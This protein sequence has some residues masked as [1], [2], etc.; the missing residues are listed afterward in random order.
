M[1]RGFDT[2]ECGIRSYEEWL[3][4]R[5]NSAHWIW[6]MPGIRKPIYA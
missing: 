5:Y 6:P 3:V 2:K 4:A 1:W